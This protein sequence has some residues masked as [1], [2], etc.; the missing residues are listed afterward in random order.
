MMITDFECL[1]GA[2]ECSTLTSEEAVGCLRYAGIR[3]S[4]PIFQNG[5]EQGVFP[6]AVAIDAGKR[7]FIIF[8]HKLEKWIAECTGMQVSVKEILEGYKKLNT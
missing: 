6:F 2:V 8:R 3:I 5:I 4:L 7:N 1:D